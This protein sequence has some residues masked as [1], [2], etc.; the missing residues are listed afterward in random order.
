MLGWR[1]VARTEK[2]TRA[3]QQNKY[4]LYD[5]EGQQT[6]TEHR[7]EHLQHPC[8]NATHVATSRSQTV[9]HQ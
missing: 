4:K 8:R 5:E 3:H 7:L 6:P 2:V 1:C 9:P